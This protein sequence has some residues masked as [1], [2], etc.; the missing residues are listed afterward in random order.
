MA[1][2]HRSAASWRVEVIG[3]NPVAATQSETK[4]V[5]AEDVGIVVVRRARMARC[6]AVEGILAAGHDRQRG[7]HALIVA[8][9]VVDICQRR[10]RSALALAAGSQRAGTAT[11]GVL[12]EK[13]VL[14]IKASSAD[15]DRSTDSAATTTA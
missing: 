1:A 5:R 2:S 12:V 7:R 10:D 15:K 13:S 8:V 11:R 6:A 3:K 9:A 14:E 4:T